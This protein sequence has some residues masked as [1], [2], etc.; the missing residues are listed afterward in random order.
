MRKLFHK[1]K[2]NGINL[3][4]DREVK[5]S[6]RFCYAKREKHDEMFIRAMMHK[7]LGI[8]LQPLVIKVMK[9]YKK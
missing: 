4:L 8:F 9:K 6:V 5:E 1:K 2:K 3:A 7:K